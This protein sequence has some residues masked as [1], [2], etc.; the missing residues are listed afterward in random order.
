MKV[1]TTQVTKNI[2]FTE[3]DLFDALSEKF[4]NMFKN[5]AYY[6]FYVSYNY[7]DKVEIC[8]ET[9]DC[10][11]ATIIVKEEIDED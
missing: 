1:K 11:K 3:E 10:L 5:V 2:Q 8:S 7:G 6:E 4:P 9:D